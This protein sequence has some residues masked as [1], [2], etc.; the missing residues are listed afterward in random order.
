M[1][2]DLARRIDAQHQRQHG[3]ALHLGTGTYAA[4]KHAVYRGRVHLDDNLTGTRNR[5]RDLFVVKNVGRTEFAENRCLH[6]AIT[7]A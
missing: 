4:I 7:S 5:V 2:D 6:T 3:I 1:G